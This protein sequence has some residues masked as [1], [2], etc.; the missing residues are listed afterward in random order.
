[1]ALA[2]MSHGGGPSAFGTLTLG[3][4]VL[5][6]RDFDARD[7]LEKI[8]RHRVTELWLS[9]TAL[10]LLLDYPDISSFDLSSLRCALLGTAGI[11]EDTLTRAV[12]TLGPCIAHSYGQIEA[13]FITLFDTTE[14]G[15]AARGVHSHR[16]LSSGRTMNVNRIA[17]MDDDGAVLPLGSE[18]E[19]V[20]RGPCV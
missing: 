6:M 1:M 19:I 10:T 8:Q 13:N 3:G 4:T 11:G 17:V 7:V 20:V 15:E 2:P 5:V 9:P 12:A 18:G 14:L 16:L